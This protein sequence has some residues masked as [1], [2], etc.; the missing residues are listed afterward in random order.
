[1]KRLLARGLVAA[2]CLAAALTATAQTT[3][4]SFSGTVEDS[5]GNP[6]AAVMT[7]SGEAGDRT[8][9]V[10]DDGRFLAGFL[11]PGTYQVR[12]EAAELSPLDDEI[13]IYLGQR[14]QRRFVLSQGIQE[15]MTVVGRTQPALDLGTQVTGANITTEEAEAIPLGQ[16]VSSMV[17]LAPSVK[18][19]GGT[20]T[21]NPSISGA[22]GLENQYVF[23][24]VNVTNAGYGALG[25]YSIIHGSQGQGI[26][27]HFVD[28][29]QVLTGGFSAEYGQATGGIVNVLTKSGS[30][31]WHGS[32]FGYATPSGPQGSFIVPPLSPPLATF[33]G[34]SRLNFGFDVSG[35]IKKDK[36]FFY[37]GLNPTEQRTT[38]RA[39]AGYPL[40]SEGDFT[41][42]LEQL[43][44]AAKLTLLPRP[45]HRIDVSLFGD[46]AETNDSFNRGS[47]VL[48]QDSKVQFSKLEYGG[49]NWNIHYQGQI[50]SRLLIDASVGN[51]NNE[52][53]ETFA[54]ENDL[55]RIINRGPL[56]EERCEDTNG[57]GVI[58]LSDAPRTCGSENE[59]GIGF[60]EKSESDNTQYKLKFTSEIN[61][62]ELSYGIGYEDIDY[63]FT[64]DYTGPNFVTHDGDTSQTGAIAYRE[65]DCSLA[66]DGSVSETL[67]VSEGDALSAAGCDA[68]QAMMLASHPCSQDPSLTC[69][70]VPVRYRVVRGKLSDPVVE[71]SSKYLYLFIDDKWSVTDNLTVN[72]GLRWEQEDLNGR[73]T[74]YSLPSE[75][76][77]RLGMSWD[78]TGEGR[79]KLY[80][81]FARFHEKVPLDI[82]VRLFS[83][84]VQV[85]VGQYYDRDLQTP[86]EGDGRYFPTGFGTT[87]V[88]PGTKT[89]RVDELVLG[90]QRQVGNVWTLKAEWQ[91][92]DLK[93]VLEDFQ[94]G[95]ATGIE[96]GYDDFGEYVVGN[97]DSSIGVNT[98]GAFERPRREYMALIL[99]ATASATRWGFSGQYTLSRLHGNYEGLFRNDNGQSDPNLTSLYDFP[100]E[101]IFHQTY[102]A[103]A[104]N[105]DR[106]HRLQAW[107]WY[108]WDNGWSIGAR[109]L[110]QTGTPKL[111]LAHHPVYGNGGEISLE[112]RGALGRTPTAWNVD[113]NFA[114]QWKLSDKL[115]SNISVEVDIFNLFNHRYET[116]FDYNSTAA[117][118]VDTTDEGSLI[119]TVAGPTVDCPECAP[120]NP[121]YGKPTA[122]ND[123]RELRVGFKWRF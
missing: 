61:R 85:L 50:G 87:R 37:L 78:H 29:V 116:A 4:G 52:F 75:W 94:T 66:G 53:D 17:F 79:S 122:Y 22:S 100:N 83:D 59:D 71:T 123:P 45:E 62:H 40:E 102:A 13:R 48:R 3:T 112:R 96:L 47:G 31:E 105:T 120:P 65:P 67:E 70:E 26:N 7:L 92:R 12:I 15:E 1:M 114:K 119:D 18:D 42:T 19:G 21:A 106:T 121:D 68:M 54:P 90:Y 74:N 57:D 93:R 60:V 8:I 36:A 24:G 34:R 104:L 107:G 55:H 80:G 117:A 32:V 98:T 86:I 72:L 110:A 56:Y 88:L 6:I 113:F 35:P 10:E 81:H 97:I 14:L 27:Y 89:S 99:Q 63:A 28:E 41:R 77:P 115:G 25:G 73:T 5:D 38:R 30:N 111:K 51:A 44:Y 95:S 46:P 91:I 33:E 2:A 84:E 118:I 39:P 23:N 11:P 109:G 76:S 64:G 58:D 49:R 82:A 108:K 20:G 103:G 16:N 69:Y 9:V 43:N 101:P